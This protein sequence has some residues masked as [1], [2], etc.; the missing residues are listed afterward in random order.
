MKNDKKL[1]EMLRAAMPAAVA[2]LHSLTVPV[3]QADSGEVAKVPLYESV[4]WDADK[5]VLSAQVL[6]ED[7]SICRDG[8]AVAECRDGLAGGNGTV[9]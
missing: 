6:V 1:K 5:G 4:E 8:A 7:N 9:H 2:K 3:R